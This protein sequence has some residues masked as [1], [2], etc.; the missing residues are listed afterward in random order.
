[1]N[2]IALGWLD[3]TPRTHVIVFFHRTVHCIVKA[4]KKKKPK[5][6]S[7]FVKRFPSTSIHNFF[8]VNYFVFSTNPNFDGKKNRQINRTKIANVC[9]E[10]SSSNAPIFFEVIDEQC[11][12]S[13]LQ[14]GIVVLLA[15]SK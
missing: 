9:R 14:S 13:R 5:K 1:M 15:R 4:K 2:L 11:T 7:T 3:E 8:H 12:G 10:N 6:I